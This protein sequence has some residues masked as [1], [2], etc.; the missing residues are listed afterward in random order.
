MFA[1]K[2]ENETG[3]SLS[4]KPGILAPDLHLSQLLSVGRKNLKGG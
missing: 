3:Q 1:F 2:P 4:F